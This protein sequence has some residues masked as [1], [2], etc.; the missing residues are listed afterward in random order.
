MSAIGCVSTHCA[1]PPRTRR[2]RSF[3]VIRNSSDLFRESIIDGFRRKFHTEFVILFLSLLAS[4]RR[5]KRS[6]D[7][8]YEL[9]FCQLEAGDKY[10]SCTKTLTLE[11]TT[12]LLIALP[13]N[14]TVETTYRRVVLRD[15]RTV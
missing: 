15:G 2:P 5:S 14:S 9:K 7:T 12:S 4:S 11:R 1:T 6:F 3:R 10:R 8:F 13:A